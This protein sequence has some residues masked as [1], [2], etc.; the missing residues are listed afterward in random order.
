M[1]TAAP[2]LNQHRIARVIL[3]AQ[4]LLNWALL[5]LHASTSRVNHRH[6]RQRY[7]LLSLEGVRQIVCALIVVRAVEIARLRGGPGKHRRDASPIGVRRRARTAG[8]MRASIGAR[9]RRALKHRD[10][11]ERIGR[12]LA[13]FADIDGYAC[14]YLV[15][16]GRLTKLRPIVMTAPQAS[17]CASLAAP[18]VCAADSS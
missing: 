1:Q 3:W 5:L 11:G 13:A 17:A 9:L 15:A 18:V 12:L 6:M 16:R 7:S 10:V 8:L 2:I 4:T 14:R